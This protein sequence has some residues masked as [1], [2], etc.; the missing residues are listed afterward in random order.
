MSGAAA[1]SPSTETVRIGIIG[2]SGYIGA[3]LLRYLVVHPGVSIE[4]V[5]ANTHV[6]KHVADVLPNLTGFLDLEFVALAEVESKLDGV[7]A[8]FVCL[9]HNQ[10]QEGIPA[11]VSKHPELVMIDMG[12][13]FRTPD[14]SGYEKYY[15]REHAAPEWLDRFVYGFTEYSREKLRA[16]R[17]VA[18]PGCFATAINL[19]LAP[20]A[21]AERLQGDVFVAATTGSS[22]AGNKPLA[23]THHPQ[24]GT[25]MRAYK[26]LVHQHLLEVEG[27]LGSLCDTQFKIHFVPQ[28]GPFV[29]GIFATVFTPGLSGE[30]LREI[31]GKAYDAEPLVSVVDGSPELRWIQGAPRAVLGVSGEGGRSVL[32]SIIDNLG[33]G[34]AGQAIQ[35]FNCIFGLPE[36]SG[37]TLPAGFV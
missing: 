15:G 24:R 34:A 5:T 37:L 30:E 28:S 2:G 13:D 22:G 14:P 17:L 9:P 19:A 20:L 33:K 7:E 27:F 16:T 23:T 3:E 4:W 1:G 8:V 18:N 35:N 31:V 12:G 6:G 26:P 36:T 25:N 32:F 21:A 10:S 11:L 29:R